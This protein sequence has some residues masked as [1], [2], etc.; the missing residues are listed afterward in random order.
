MSEPKVSSDNGRVLSSQDH[1]VLQGAVQTHV[2]RRTGACM[3]CCCRCWSPLRNG[4]AA[5]FLLLLSVFIEEFSLIMFGR[6]LGYSF[7]F[8]SHIYYHYCPTAVK[9]KPRH[10]RLM[11]TTTTETK[12]KYINKL[13][14]GLF[15]L[16][17]VNPSFLLK[18]IS[19]YRVTQGQTETDTPAEAK[20]D[21]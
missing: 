12:P 4:Y 5:T 11:R 17:D 21:S 18:C 10:F 15:K 3:P 6:T 2:I 14:R 7:F 20:G 9:K 16:P 19:S 13:Q 8:S 1:V